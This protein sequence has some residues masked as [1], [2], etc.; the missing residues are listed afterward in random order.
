MVSNFYQFDFKHLTTNESH[1][2]LKCRAKVNEILAREAYE[3]YNSMN[4]P[5]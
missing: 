1:F 2:P 5:T 3:M 4:V